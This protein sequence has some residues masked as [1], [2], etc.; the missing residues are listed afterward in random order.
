MVNCCVNFELLSTAQNFSFLFL[1]HCPCPLEIDMETQRTLG[2][3]VDC[4]AVSYILLPTFRLT[5]DRWREIAKE[6]Y[7]DYVTSTMT[8]YAFA[9][10]F[11][12]EMLLCEFQQKLTKGSIVLHGL[13]EQ[14]DSMFEGERQQDCLSHLEQWISFVRDSST[15]ASFM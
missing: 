15:A 6:R 2:E 7:A 8:T 4:F 10:L 9:K 5:H 3:K 12:D 11:S 14:F 13:G 1:L